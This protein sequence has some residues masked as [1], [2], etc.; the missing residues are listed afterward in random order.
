VSKGVVSPVQ[1]SGGACA[2]SYATS[3]IGA[4]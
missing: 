1:N 4:L 3:A 2:A